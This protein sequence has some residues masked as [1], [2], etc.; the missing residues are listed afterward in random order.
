MATENA[1]EDGTGTNI[2][3]LRKA[4]GLTQDQLAQR[5]NVSKSLLSKVEIGD[6]PASHGLVASVARALRVP[7]ERVH[8]QPYD[9]AENATHAPIDEL[10]AVLRR[11]DLPPGDE[12]EPR[13]LTTLRAEVITVAELRRSGHYARLGERLPDLLTELTAVALTASGDDR[14]AAFGLLTSGYYAAHGLAYRL[15]YG[16]LAESIEHKLGWAAE[17]A[18]DPLAVGLAAWTRVNSFQ[19]A[20]NYDHGLQ[21]LDRARADLAHHTDL[22]GPAALTLTGSMHLRAV[23]LASRGG[24]AATVRDHLNVAHRL[25]DEVGGDDRIHYHLTFGQVNTHIHAVA[26]HIELGEVDQAVTLADNFVPPNS[27]PPTRAGHHFIDLA[28]AHL[29]AGDRAATLRAL[30]QARRR[31]PEQT[32]YHPMVRETTRVLVSLHRRSNRDLTRF[33]SWLGLTA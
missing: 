29:M 10:R 28:R 19:A 21:I 4:A 27:V 15:G 24:D 32:R 18:E 8:G 25:A 22:P 1:S 3:L 33:A 26:A 20:G 16:D 9:A 31:A 7:I 12:V 17:R 11:Y 23:T 13:P 5:A 14:R 6:R 2:A 30:Q